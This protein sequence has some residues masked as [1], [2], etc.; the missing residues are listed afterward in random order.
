[1]RCPPSGRRS[2]SNAPGTRALG[3]SPRADDRPRPRSHPPDGS[4]R[5]R[6][7]ASRGRPREAPPPRAARPLRL[8]RPPTRARRAHVRLRPLAHPAAG[9]IAL[10]LGAGLAYVV[11]GVFV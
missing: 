4:A 6:R 3:D 9:T 10:Y 11:V 2:Y 8:L 1:R 5:L 7:G